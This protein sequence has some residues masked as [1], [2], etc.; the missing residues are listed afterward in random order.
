MLIEFIGQECP[1][2][3]NME[4][5]VTQLEQEEVIKIERIEV[6]HNED[7]LKKMEGY[8]KDR[9]GG[10]PFFYNT[11]TQKSICGETSFEE[12]KKW[13]LGVTKFADHSPVK[14][15]DN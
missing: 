6:W 15:K 2:C 14:Q 9:C 1:H 8:D 11:D 7:N 3:Q 10:V 4:S 12:L 5:L 13:A